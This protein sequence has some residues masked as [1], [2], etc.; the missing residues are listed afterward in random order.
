MAV[1]HCRLY[2]RAISDALRPFP[3]GRALQERHTAQALC[4]RE[5]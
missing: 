2:E 4:F 1:V 3:V 5:A